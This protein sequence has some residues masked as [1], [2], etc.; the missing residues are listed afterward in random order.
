MKV[1]GENRETKQIDPEVSCK[2][3][4]LVFDPS[5]AVVEVLSGNGIKSQEKAASDDVSA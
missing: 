3:F 1:I 2:Q 4:T 5:F